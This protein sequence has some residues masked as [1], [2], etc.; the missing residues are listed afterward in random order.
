MNWF[1]PFRRRKTASVAR[2]RLQILLTHERGAEGQS[3]LIPLL[4]EEVLAAVAKH[5]P[6]DVDKVQV[7]IERGKAVS[8]LEID[9]EIPCD[10]EPAKRRDRASR[11]KLSQRLANA[12]A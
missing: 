11:S 3:D 5:V 10:P 9:I 12:Q 7:K 8:L 1:F 6:V 4:R 2:E